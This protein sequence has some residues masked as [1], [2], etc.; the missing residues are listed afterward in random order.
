MNPRVY[1]KDENKQSTYSHSAE[2]TAHVPFL[3]HQILEVDCA[4]RE[5]IYT[6]VNHDI[7]LGIP[8]GTVAEGEKIHFE[9]YRCGTV[10]Q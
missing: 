7:T 10:C 2:K 3:D 6:N 4:E 9:V 1:H 5:Y 8:E